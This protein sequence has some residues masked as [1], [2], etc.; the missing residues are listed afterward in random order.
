VAYS[1]EISLRGERDRG[2]LVAGTSGELD[3]AIDRILTA[4]QLYHPPTMFVRERP[5]FGPAGVPGHGLKLGVDQAAGYGALAYLGEFDEISGTWI[6]A[7]ETAPADGPTLYLD[8]DN[9]TE[10]PPNSLVPLDMWRLALHEFLTS[11]GNRPICVGWQPAD[12]W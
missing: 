12:T 5:R 2:P 6:T 11:G 4:G 3:E 1:V 10:F 9:A 8:F 7:S